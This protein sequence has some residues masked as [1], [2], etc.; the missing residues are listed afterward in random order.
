MTASSTVKFMSLIKATLM[1]VIFMNGYSSGTPYDQENYQ[2][3]HSKTDKPP[4]PRPFSL[5]STR[6]KRQNYP[7]SIQDV[8]KENS[9]NNMERIGGS[10][11]SLHVE[12]PSMLQHFRP[13]D[14]SEV[15]LLATTS[16]RFSSLPTAENGRTQNE[17]HGENKFNIVEMIQRKRPFTMTLSVIPVENENEMEFFDHMWKTKMQKVQKT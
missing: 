15:N 2:I 3:I 13:N 7:T 6:D 11:I 12:R 8:L 1:V 4:L 14:P 17:R 9:S 10:K 16:F 5:D